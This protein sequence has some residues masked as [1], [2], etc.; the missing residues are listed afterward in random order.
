MTVIIKAKDTPEC[1]KLLNTRRIFWTT[2]VPVY[3]RLHHC[4]LLVPCNYHTFARN[5]FEP[6][7]LLNEILD[8]P[9]ETAHIRIYL[10]DNDKVFLLLLIEVVHI[11]MFVCYVHSS[12][13]APHHT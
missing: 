7:P 13:S 12:E 11:S 5:N 6:S 2:P 4:P 1:S 10:C 9:L 3:L 8:T